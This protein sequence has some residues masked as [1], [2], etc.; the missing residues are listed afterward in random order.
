MGT[1]ARLSVV[2][3]P[4]TERLA[5]T[6]LGNTANALGTV[7]MYPLGPWLCTR[8]SELP[9]L[10]GALAAASVLPFFFATLYFP[11]AP[12]T[13][14]SAA[15][16][17]AAHLEAPVDDAP[18]TRATRSYAFTILAAGLVAGSSTAWQSTFQTTLRGLAPAKIGWLGF[19]T[20]ASG[21]AGACLVAAAT[22][23]RRQTRLKAALVSLLA[24]A[25]AAAGA[26]SV[27]DLSYGNGLLL[28]TAI[29]LFQGASEPFFVELAAELLPIR[30][31]TS[32]GLLVLIWNASCGI[33]LFVPPSLG[34]V[35]D[36]TYAGTLCATALL[37]ASV[38][39][40]HCR[41]QDAVAADDAAAMT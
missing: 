15:A 23:G 24:A 10:V 36:W 19:A 27:L 2:W 21:I 31:T 30:E 32:N 1:V 41:P 17:A 35:L 22:A 5:A 25:A 39:E 34:R 26:W 33:M 12:S 37:V 16:A 40:V 6:S 11:A 3:F 7:L 13:P 28:A 18:K 20:T 14:P 38:A 4:E 8:S 9:R 29:G